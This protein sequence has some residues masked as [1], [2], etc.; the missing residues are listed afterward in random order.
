MLYSDGVHLV[1]SESLDELHFFVKALELSHAGFIVL[2]INLI[3]IFQKRKG[4]PFLS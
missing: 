2:K 4:Q 3:M 1:S